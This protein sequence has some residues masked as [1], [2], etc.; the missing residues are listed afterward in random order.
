MKAI[1]Y[2]VVAVLLAAATLG[3]PTGC[4]CSKPAEW[5]IEITASTLEVEAGGSITLSAESVTPVGENASGNAEY[6]RKPVKVA[7]S[8]TPSAGAGTG[9][10]SPESGES[11]TFTSDDPGEYKI[12]GLAGDGLSDYLY[13]KVVPSTYLLNIS[14]GLVV[15]GGGKAPSFTIESPHII[16]EM[17]SYNYGDGDGS[18][19]AGTLALQAA[20]GTLHGPWQCTADEGQ[21][22][23]P[24][25]LWFAY[26]DEEIPAGTYTVVNS[27]PGTWSHNEE[28]GGL[29]FC[30]VK[31]TPV[32]Q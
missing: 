5:S 14:N 29:G 15:T 10:C 20:D 24:N 26:P 6:E 21:G 11:T 18:P 22:G 2:G 28:S 17:Y 4:S 8:V 9:M 1:R 31:G 23:V 32:D 12:V 16:T 13:V 30:Y 27:N 25:A 3:G 19:A 7:W